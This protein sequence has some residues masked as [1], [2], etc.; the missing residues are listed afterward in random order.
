MIGNDVQPKR[1][2]RR[3]LHS[4]QRPKRKSYARTVKEWDVKLMRESERDDFRY[5]ALMQMAS[6]ILSP[7]EYEDHDDEDRIILAEECMERAE[8]FRKLSGEKMSAAFP[9]TKG[10]K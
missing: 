3:Y 5:R 1:K 9:K 8:T 2:G 6:H 4:S 10:K 7:S